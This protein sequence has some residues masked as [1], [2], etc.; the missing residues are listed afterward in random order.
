MS[1]VKSDRFCT[2]LDKNVYV[3]VYYTIASIRGTSSAI[4]TGVEC[5]ASPNGT[6]GKYE[7]CLALREAEDDVRNKKLQ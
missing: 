4:P 7:A 1:Q 3:I 6:C 5:S 2:Y